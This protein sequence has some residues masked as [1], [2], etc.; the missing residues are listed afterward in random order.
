MDN[1]IAPWAYRASKHEKE[2]TAF[3]KAAEAKEAKKQAE[4]AK[5]ELE[6][7]TNRDAVP[8]G[9]SYSPGGT[10]NV[11]GHYRTSKTGKTYYV[12]PHTRKK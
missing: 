4:V 3:A 2:S 11:K 5:R 10:V 8:S 9:S 6:T 12:Q 7:S 1:P